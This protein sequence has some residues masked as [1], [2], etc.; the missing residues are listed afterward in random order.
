MRFFPVVRPFSD[1]ESIYPSLT[2]FPKMLVFEQ[3]VI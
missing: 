3:E 1:S 2:H